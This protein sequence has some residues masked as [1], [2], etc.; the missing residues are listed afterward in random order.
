VKA[1]V[2]GRDRKKIRRVAF[3]LGH[4][5]VKVDRRPPFTAVFRRRHRGRSHRHRIAARVRMKDG[6]RVK[7]RRRLRFCAHG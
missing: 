7:L 4:G 3:R 6:R 1:R 2:T 5:R